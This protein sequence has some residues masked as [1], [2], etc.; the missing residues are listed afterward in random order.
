MV[1]LLLYFVAGIL[2][3]LH[4]LPFSYRK[5]EKIEIFMCLYPISRVLNS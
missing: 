4:K 2:V 3:L 5:I 1:D